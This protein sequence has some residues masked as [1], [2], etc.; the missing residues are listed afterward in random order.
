MQRSK[1]LG[2]IVFW[3]PLTLSCLCFGQTKSLSG[4]NV[5]DFADKPVKEQKWEKNPF[6]QNTA[7]D[8]GGLTLYA[9]AYNPAQGSVALINQRIVEE[10]DRI[11]TSEIQE[12]TPD[13]VIVR[14][15]GG[16]FQLNFGGVK[17]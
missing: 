12:I 6:L 17:K 13:A 8:S 2:G 10:G 16:I 15:E 7:S 3:G 4:L 5:Q 11:G 1:L 9:I 14:N